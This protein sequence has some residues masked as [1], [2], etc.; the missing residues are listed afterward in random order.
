M[1]RKAATLL[2]PA[3]EEATQEFACT[4]ASSLRARRSCRGRARHA[5]TRTENRYQPPSGLGTSYRQVSL[6][7]AGPA[8]RNM[9]Q[10]KGNALANVATHHK[11]QPP[12]INRRLARATLRHGLGL[13][14]HSFS[15]PWRAKSGGFSSGGSHSKSLCSSAS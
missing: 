13:W 4:W 1:K 11:E 6:A 15:R 8:F 5:N 3:S 14:P 12:I 2:L 10:R 9:F 7:T